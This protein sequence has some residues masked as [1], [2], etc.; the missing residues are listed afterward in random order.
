MS[1]GF[2]NFPLVRFREAETCVVSTS[3]S[4]WSLR[5]G[6]GGDGL[7]FFNSLPDQ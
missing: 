2:N 7:Y 6:T 5:L 3:R 1:L 4:F